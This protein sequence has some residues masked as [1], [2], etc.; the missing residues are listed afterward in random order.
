M[1]IGEY[2]E[3]A[4]ETAVYPDKGEGNFVYPALGLAGEA[5]EVAEKVKKILRDDGGELGETKKKQLSDEL[6][7]VL[8]YW[9]TLCRELD[10][11]PAEVAR[12]NVAKLNDRAERGCLGGSGDRR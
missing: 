6:G 1:K 8:W 4:K 2:S 3:Q 12:Q 9:A 5:G 11:D 7:D 10:L